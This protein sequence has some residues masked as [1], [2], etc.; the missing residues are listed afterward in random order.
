MRSPRWALACPLFAGL[1]FPGFLEFACG[2]VLPADQLHGIIC[3]AFLADWL[4]VGAAVVP[5]GL[6]CGLGLLPFCPGR[7]RG[8][9]G[10]FG[11]SSE[12]SRSKAVPCRKAK[13]VTGWGV[14]F[15]RVVG[16]G[17]DSGWA[18]TGLS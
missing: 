8:R 17:V 16:G 15:V 13:G 18:R 7:L 6:S 12:A 11:V 14:I 1:A 4:I 5:A 10:G 9:L 2:F 3:A